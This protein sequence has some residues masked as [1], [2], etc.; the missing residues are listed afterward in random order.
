MT[1]E[2]TAF[3]AECQ[4]QPTA[5]RSG[6]DRWAAFRELRAMGLVKLIRWGACV[7]LVRVVEQKR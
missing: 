3:L 6:G 2:A 5:I 7:W 4:A 1:P